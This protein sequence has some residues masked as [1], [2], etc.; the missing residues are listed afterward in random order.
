MFK[1]N[2][3][4]F[5]ILSDAVSE[6]IVI[7]DANRNIV[8]TNI[9]ADV[10]FG[11][12]KHELIGKGLNILIPQNHH[13]KH[14]I[15]FEVFYKNSEKR[16]MGHGRD[17]FG[18]HKNGHQFP[19]EVGLNP[20]TIFDNTYVMALIIDITERK[21]AEQERNYLS[22]IF[23]DSLNEI[24]VFDLVS[25]KFINANYGAQKNLGYSL[26]ELKE[27]TLMDIKPGFIEK[28][29]RKLTEPLVKK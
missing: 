28:K 6:G 7:V 23:D 2:K 17:L 26:G 3:D 16:K 21:Q 10:M 11:Y 12:N 24:Y 4:I 14:D 22:K 25:L 15:Y 18:L 27:M 19:V 8:S 1:D 9:S 20:F 13:S 29:I 5:Q